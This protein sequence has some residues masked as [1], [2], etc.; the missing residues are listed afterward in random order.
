ME[1]VASDITMEYEYQ[2]K[3]TFLCFPSCNLQ[4][5]GKNY[6]Q[7]M[8][9]T[10]AAQNQLNFKLQPEKELNTSDVQLYSVRFWRH[11]FFYFYKL[12]FLKV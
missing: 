6:S 3:G 8:Y 1:W 10:G 4:F 2:L 9:N 7:T 5:Q 12:I 11:Q